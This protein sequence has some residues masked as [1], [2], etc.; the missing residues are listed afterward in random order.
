MMV[1][2]VLVILI[3]TFIAYK[4]RC[5]LKNYNVTLQRLVTGRPGFSNL[6]YPIVDEH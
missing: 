6:M 2:A 1:P 5:K 3:V 4:L